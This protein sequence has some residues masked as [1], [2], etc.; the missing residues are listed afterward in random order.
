MLDGVS[1][2]DRS[3]LAAGAVVT[4]DVPAGAIVGGNPA[5]RRADRPRPVRRR[6]GRGPAARPGA[7][8]AAGPGPG[9]P[10]A[11]VAGPGHRAGRRPPARRLRSTGRQRLG[12]PRCRLPRPVRRVRAGAAGQPG[13]GWTPSAPRCTGTG[14]TARAARPKPCSGGC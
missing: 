4:K 8:P 5:G 12:R 11:R 3:V 10:V 13:R 2:G 7:R 9:P 6:R 1:V 14:G